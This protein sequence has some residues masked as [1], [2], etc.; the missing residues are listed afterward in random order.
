MEEKIK[1]YWRKIQKNC[2]DELKLKRWN[3]VS[4]QSKLNNVLINKYLYEKRPD[5][6]ILN[7]LGRNKNK[8]KLYDD[9]KLLENGDYTGLTYSTKYRVQ[10]ILLNISDKYTFI[11]VEIE[12]NDLQWYSMPHLVS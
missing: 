1:K 4:I 10:N 11:K 6:V 3:V 7:E 5:F 9:Y 8:M 2:N 12:K